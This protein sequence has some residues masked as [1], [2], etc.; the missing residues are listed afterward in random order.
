MQVNINLCLFQA[1][2]GPGFQIPHVTVYFMLNHLKWELLFVFAMLDKLKQ[3]QQNSTFIVV[4]YLTFTLLSLTA[5]I[6]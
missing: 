5:K 2:T 4:N 1:S 6:N 3:I